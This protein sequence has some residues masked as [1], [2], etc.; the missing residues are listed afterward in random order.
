MKEENKIFERAQK[1]YDEKNWDAAIDDC[2]TLVLKTR[3]D[4]KNY[5]K[6]YAL[7]CKACNEKQ[8]TQTIE[9][10]MAPYAEKIAKL[11]AEL[12]K[13][14]KKSFDFDDFLGTD[15]CAHTEFVAALAFFEE[16]ELLE[17]CLTEDFALIN[18]RVRPQFSFY[19]PTPLYFITGTSTRVKMKDPCKMLRFLVKHGANPN[20]PDGEGTTP[21]WN[22]SC[23]RGSIEMLKTLLEL[24]ANPNQTSIVSEEGA[25]TPL[26]NCLLPDNDENDESIWHPFN[27][28]DIQKAKFLLEYGADP[29]FTT[30]LFQDCPPLVLA[31]YYGITKT[32]CK[33]PFALEVLKFIELLLNKGADPNF[34]DTKGNLPLSFTLEK[35]LFEVGQLLLLYGAKM[36]EKEPEEEELPETEE[37]KFIVSE[38]GTEKT[39]KEILDTISD[40]DDGRLMIPRPATPKDINLCNANLDDSGLPELPKDYIKF[41]KIWGGYAYDGI[42]FY[43]TDH[44][45]DPED[46]YALIDIVTATDDFNDYY[47]YSDEP[48]LEDAELCIGRQNGDYFTYNPETKKY[49]VRSHEC[50]TDIW[51]E[52]DTFE[53]LFMKEVLGWSKIKM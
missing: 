24:G 45:Y 43:G 21:L 9:E 34:K 12:S 13:Q 32:N 38:D 23:R 17:L 3:K 40:N 8:A 36:P 39:F 19:E 20:I 25:V 37:K 27:T 29:N 30:P 44:V 16:Y 22:Q 18:A 1:A 51:D 7:L 48:W 42:E 14:A 31:I 26:I 47:V 11:K 5:E 46:D 52:Y 15:V 35:H 53:E 4:D 49:Q 6:Y 10:R 41:L 2:N 28:E 33:E 50:I